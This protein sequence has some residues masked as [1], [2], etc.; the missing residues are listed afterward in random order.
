MIRKPDPYAYVVVALTVSAALAYL[1]LPHEL[2]PRH[3]FD[4]ASD[5]YQ[6]LNDVR[7][8]ALQLLGG[9]VLVVGSYVAARTLRLNREGHITDRF[10]KAVEHL[11]G[12][13]P[14]TRLGGIYAMER[15]MRDAPSE[16]GA[17][18]E[19][20]TA[21]VRVEA[22]KPRADPRTPPIDVEAVL[23]VVGRRDARSDPDDVLFRLNFSGAN[24]SY[25]SMRDGNYVRAN[26]RQTNLEYAYLVRSNFARALFVGARLTNAKVE[27]A[28]FA[29]ATADV[30][31]IWP[32]HVDASTLGLVPDAGQ[33]S[34]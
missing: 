33:L 24:L 20:L 31:T 22:T 10:S 17:I 5:W 8:S 16:Q 18:L 11:G 23:R 19:V 27:G 12:A 21:F 7:T 9:F 28:A 14:A 1:V 6:A 13:D 32:A 3:D 29:G 34:S 15:I 4:K 26:F 2:V 30:D 25:C